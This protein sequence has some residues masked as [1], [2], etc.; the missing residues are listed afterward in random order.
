MASHYFPDNGS[1]HLRGRFRFAPGPQTAGHLF[2]IGIDEMGG[3]A[4]Q[5]SVAGFFDFEFRARP[6]SPRFPDALRHNDLA[7]GRKPCGFHR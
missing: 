7:L 5:D 3:R 6:P 4:E 1:T 2:E